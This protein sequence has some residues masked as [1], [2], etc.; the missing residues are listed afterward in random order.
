M[1]SVRGVSKSYGSRAVLQGVDLDVATGERLALI[2]PNGAGKTTLLRILSTL[3]RPS[4]GTVCIAGMDPKDRAV[5][6]R[7]RIGFLSHQPLLYDDLSAQEN[8]RFFGRM[9]GVADLDGRISSMLGRVGLERSRRD[10]V[11]TFSRGMKQRLAIARALLHDPP[12]LLFDE[13]YTGLD[14]HAAQMLDAVLEGTGPAPRTVVWTT[15]QLEQG[16][17][18]SQRAMILARGRLVYEIK[19]T[20]SRD[21]DVLGQEYERYAAGGVTA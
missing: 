1:I 6:I 12:L 8:L 11:R 19:V 20:G 17:D 15:H 9:Y 21:L 3:S 16:L 18:A 14:R 4:A 10:P 5:E 7:R 13:P 2:G